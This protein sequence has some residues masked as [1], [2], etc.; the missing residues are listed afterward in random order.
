MQ[1]SVAR[2]L[3][4]VAFVLALMPATALA[5][6]GIG[7]TSGFASG[8]FH[9][10]LGADHVL[11]MVAVGLWAAQLGGR[12]TWILPCAFVVVMIL[13]GA[14]GMVNGP[15]P[16]VEQGILA[17]VLVL[18]VLIAAAVRFP[19]ALS[20][21]VVGLFAFFH[22]HAHGTEMPVA[23]GSVA[24][25]AGFATATVLLH[26]AGIGIGAIFT[27]LS[28]DRIARYAGG[29]IAALGLYLAFGV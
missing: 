24:Y 20:V 7:E 15:A 5:H 17:S 26:A 22:G 13:G 19:T 10:I 27:K 21:A 28:L 29:A 16:F 14:L 12:K 1:R 4:M 18:G 11:A 2:V 8:F 9:P 23:V 6:V 3:L 25:S